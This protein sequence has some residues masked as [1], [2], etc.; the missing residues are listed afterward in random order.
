MVLAERSYKASYFDY[1]FGVKSYGRLVEDD[2]RRVAN[3]SLCDSNSL[4][5]SFGEVTDKAL[6][7]VTYL[8]YLAYLFEMF[9][10]GKCTALK[11]VVEIEIFVYCHIE[12]YGGLLGEIAYH[13][14]CSDRV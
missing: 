2:Y 4:S 5:I 10:A 14:F 3:K 12:I 13:F 6:S 8:N 9:L 7:D 1:L 11:V